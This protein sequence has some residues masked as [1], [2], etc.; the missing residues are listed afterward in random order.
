MA[1][2]LGLW[3]NKVNPSTG[4]FYAKYLA[5]YLKMVMNMTW[6]V[7]SWEDLNGLDTNGMEEIY[8]AKKVLSTKPGG[9]GKRRG[10]PNF[11]VVRRVRVGRG[12]GLV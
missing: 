7:S 4:K 1:P 8:P 2:R 5:W 9:N 3:D 12:K 10:I 11:E 6:S